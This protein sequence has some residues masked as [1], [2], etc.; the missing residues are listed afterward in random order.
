MAERI[1]FYAQV[2]ARGGGFSLP[3]RGASMGC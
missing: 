1:R 2:V 3:G